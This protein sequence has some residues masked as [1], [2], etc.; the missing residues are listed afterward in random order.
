MQDRFNFQSIFPSNIAKR[1]KIAINFNCLTFLIIF[2]QKQNLFLFFG[3]NEINES[4]LLSRG[5][6]D[7]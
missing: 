6:R 5:I 4:H 1:E 3:E 7:K 2:K